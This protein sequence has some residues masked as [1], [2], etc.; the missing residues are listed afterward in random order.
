[1]GPGGEELLD[2]G[3]GEARTRE[4]GEAIHRHRL[5]HLA[6]VGADHALAERRAQQRL[7]KPLAASGTARNSP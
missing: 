1:M 7:V 5:E 6:E 2:V 3:L 4:P